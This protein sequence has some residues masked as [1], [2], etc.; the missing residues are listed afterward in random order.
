VSRRS[1]KDVRASKL[2]QW[3]RKKESR[4]KKSEDYANGQRFFNLI[5]NNEKGAN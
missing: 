1:S 4:K 2:T 5:K 3:Q